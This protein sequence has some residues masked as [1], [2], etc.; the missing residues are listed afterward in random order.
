MKVIGASALLAAPILE[1]APVNHIIC[2]AGYLKQ[3][4]ELGVPK[5]H[6]WTSGVRPGIDAHAQGC[7][8]QVDASG[9]CCSEA[10]R[11]HVLLSYRQ[12]DDV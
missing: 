11:R 4:R 2:W 12:S 7:Q 6:M 5:R 9:F 8:R 1:Y 3:P 10:C